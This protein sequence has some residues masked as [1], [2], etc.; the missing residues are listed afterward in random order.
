MR[1]DEKWSYTYEQIEEY[2]LECGASKNGAVYSL[3]DCEVRLQDLPNR[4]FGRLTFPQTRV[5]IEGTG[6][7]EFYRRFRLNFLTGGG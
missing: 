5:I 3:A 4:P 2:L 7:A 1:I 6:A